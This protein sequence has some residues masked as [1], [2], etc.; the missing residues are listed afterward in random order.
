LSK[1]SSFSENLRKW[2]ST[3]EIL[4][5]RQRRLEV[6]NRAKDDRFATFQTPQKKPMLGTYCF[7][8]LLMLHYGHGRL[9]R[10]LPA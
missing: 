2:Y 9:K 5:A 3:R 4:G 6:I 1:L 8:W 7:F 10:P